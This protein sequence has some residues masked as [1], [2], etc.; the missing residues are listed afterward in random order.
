MAQQKCRLGVLVGNNVPLCVFPTQVPTAGFFNGI[1]RHS[2]TDLSS[3]KGP[4]NNYHFQGESNHDSPSIL[5]KEQSLFCP[6]L[7]HNTYQHYREL[8]IIIINFFWF[9]EN[10]VPAYTNRQEGILLHPCTVCSSTGLAGTRVNL[11]K[12]I[13]M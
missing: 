5:N 6:I 10:A 8:E 7:E 13:N 2:L 1:I 4:A 11:I 3:I 12:T 9:H